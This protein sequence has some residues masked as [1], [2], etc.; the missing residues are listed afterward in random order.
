MR[1]VR[2]I[3]HGRVQGVGYRA[4]FAETARTEG[5]AGWVRNRRDG[6][7]EALICGAP[8]RVDHVIAIARKGPTEASVRDVAT[9]DAEPEANLTSE[10]AVRATD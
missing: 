2:L 7:V 9:T 1:S 6:T 8:D 5:L 10:F 4:W 3:I